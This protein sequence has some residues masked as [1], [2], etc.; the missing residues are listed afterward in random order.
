VPHLQS[1]NI[2]TKHIFSPIKAL[3][4]IFLILSSS[5]NLIQ[6][7]SSLS[8]SMDFISL[9]RVSSCL[10]M[11][12]S[13]PC[14]TESEFLELHML[15]NYYETQEKIIFLSY[16][17]MIES[18]YLGQLRFIPFRQLSCTYWSYNDLYVWVY[19]TQG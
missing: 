15:K 4:S 14:Q 3:F 8:L 19:L 6:S 1:I 11:G 5:L 18:Y 7:S 17:C 10:I 12:D 13:E 9:S 2:S 16:K